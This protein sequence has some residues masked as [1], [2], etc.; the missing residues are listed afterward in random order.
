MIRTIT[1]AIVDPGSRFSADMDDTFNGGA[2]DVIIPY[3]PLKKYQ[4]KNSEPVKKYK[5]KP[6]S[7]ETSE[8]MINIVEEEFEVSFNRFSTSTVEPFENN[9]TLSGNETLSDE[10]DGNLTVFQN[11]TEN[12]AEDVTAGESLEMD[13]KMAVA[14]ATSVE[15][16]V[17]H[18]SGLDTGSITGI[19]L[20]IV[21]VSGLFGS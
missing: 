1:I 4:S 7:Q 15:Q 12:Y 18:S 19:T 6:K 10:P 2:S 14:A 16:E 3:Y 5:T 21:V 11:G 9:M 20:G 17:F 13:G 8:K